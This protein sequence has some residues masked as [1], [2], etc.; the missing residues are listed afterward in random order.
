MFPVTRPS[1]KM[2]PTPANLFFYFTKITRKALFSQCLTI[3]FW[4]P[5]FPPIL[6]TKS[7]LAKQKLYKKKS[8]LPTLTF[9]GMWQETNILFF[10]GL[11]CDAKYRSFLIYHHD[12]V[13]SVCLH[14]LYF[15]LV[16]TYTVT[17]YNM[18][19]LIQGQL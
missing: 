12:N 14:A 7:L 8:D 3:L 1:L 6:S 16:F 19:V 10:L 5:D 4:N 9:L 13:Q 18:L 2:V 17:L 15:F 11:M